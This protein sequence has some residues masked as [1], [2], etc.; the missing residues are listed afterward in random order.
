MISGFLLA[1]YSV[2]ANDAV[3]TLGTF[4]SSNSHRPWWVLWLFTC[5]VLT[6]VLVYGWFFYHGDVSYGRLEI[7]PVPQSFT[8]V[9]LIPPLV[10]LGL[11]RFGIPVST[12]VLILTVFAPEALGDILIKSIL[13]YWVALIASLII[14]TLIT[15]KLEE[16]FIKTKDQEIS[17]LWI[18][19][20][21]LAT[22]FL[23][24]QWLIQDFANIFTYL[25]RTLSWKWLIF[26][27][28]VMG[29]LQAA[30][31][32]SQGG[33][34][35]EIVT[36]KTNTQDIRSATLIDFIYGFILLIF[37][38]Y[39]NIPMSTTWVFL[40]LLA[41]REMA[42]TFIDQNRSFRETGKIVVNDV[43]K[44]FTGL[45]VSLIVAFGLPLFVKLMT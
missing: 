8:W 19:L 22:G 35:Q 32:Y 1:S 15:R 25:P 28:V 17:L 38:E 5:S 20:Q 29:I 42:M 7:I 16:Y 45:V 39:S 36:S 4:L 21:W 44:A 31:F 23:W 18:I 13:G 41:G 12:T 14:Y 43:F 11:T 33:K 27:L 6:A 40:G 24:S 3:Q 37:K 30:I 26:S 10:L 9:Y 34:I 2:V